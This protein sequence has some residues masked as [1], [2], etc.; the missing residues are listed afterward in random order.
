M[1][2]EPSLVAY[3]VAGDPSPEAS[4]ELASAVLELADV[5]ELGVPF[6]DPIADGPTIQRGVQRALKAGTR[7]SHVLDIARALKRERGKPIVLMTYYNPVLR[8]GVRR[9]VEDL[10]SA[11]VDALIV[12]DLP[13]DEADELLDSCRESG[14]GTVFLASPNTPDDRLRL[15]CERSTAFVYLVSLYGTTGAREE[16]SPLALALLERAKRVC[17]RPLAVGFGVSR[18][19][20]VERLV[21]EG[22]DGVVVGSAFVEIVERL[23][24]GAGPALAEKARELKEAVSRAARA[25]GSAR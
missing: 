9:F 21:E 19:E 23:G 18:P 2:D 20:H 4:L 16:L 11:G 12:V 14:V 15:I 7:L 8:R 5:L 10:A 6:S 1:L 24:A 3:L 17:S 22:A 25:R 13:V